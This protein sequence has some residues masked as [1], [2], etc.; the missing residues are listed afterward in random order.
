M[1]RPLN[2][3]PA[4]CPW[5]EVTELV[6]APNVKWCETTRCGWISEP[7]NTWS[8]VGYLVVA[9]ACW[10]FARSLRGATL[11]LFARTT[12]LVGLCSFVYH[13]S[14]NYLTQVLD[15]VGMFLYVYLLV[16]L[17]LVR[18]WPVLR[19]WQSH[20]YWTLVGTSVGLVHLMHELALHYQLLIALAVLVVVATELGCMVRGDWRR[21]RYRAFGLSL[22][23]IVV[24][25]AFSLADLSRRWCHP[26]NL[27]LHGHAI[28]HL[29]G[30]VSIFFAFLHYR[31]MDLE[32]SVRATASAG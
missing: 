30:A 32:S 27:A 16:R 13:A 6:G 20:I 21:Y 15:F 24:A 17:N 19:A 12:A 29:L 11:G 4:G 23:L 7:A 25:Q 3:H 9:V 1:A 2:P 28:W 5:H 14:N 8:N 31:Q 10:R 22:L 26:D 18:L